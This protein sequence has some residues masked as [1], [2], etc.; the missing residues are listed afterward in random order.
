MVYYGNGAGNT[1]M[2]LQASSGTT[3]FTAT[4]GGSIYAA[5]TVT[6]GQVLVSSW[7]GKLYA[8]GL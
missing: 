2:A 6:G 3:L 8:F 1:F 4:L 5:P 7:D